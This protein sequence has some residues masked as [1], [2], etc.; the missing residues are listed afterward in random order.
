MYDYNNFSGSV[1]IIHFVYENG[2]IL[3]VSGYDKIDD[4]K[5]KWCLLNKD[6][7]PQYKD[8]QEKLYPFSSSAA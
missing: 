2:F 8:S 5:K 1:V 3:N 6:R 4:I 7:Y